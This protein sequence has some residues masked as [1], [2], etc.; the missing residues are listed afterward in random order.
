[1]ALRNKCIF[2]GRTGNDIKV[3]NFENG[4]SIGNVSLA[5]DDSY[6]NKS[7]GEKIERTVWVNLVLRGKL[8]D[9]FLNYVKK[10]VKIAVETSYSTREWQNEQGEKRYAHEFNVL[11]FE[12]MQSKNT[13]TTE[14]QKQNNDGL[15]F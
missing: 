12:F 2:I 9:V 11:G 7:T 5:V 14:N 10:G 3:T 1:M 13:E 4:N 15:P 6:T 8:V